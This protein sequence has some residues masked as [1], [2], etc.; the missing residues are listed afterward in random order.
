VGQRGRQRLDGIPGVL[1]IIEE[2]LFC[3][4]V[5]EEFEFCARLDDETKES[6]AVRASARTNIASPVRVFLIYFLLGKIA[7]ANEAR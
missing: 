2:L 7:V 4:S 6:C 3:I 1:C 5:V